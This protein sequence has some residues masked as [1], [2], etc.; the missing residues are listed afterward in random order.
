M[1]GQTITCRFCN[2]PVRLEDTRT[3]E[4]GKA[5]HEECYVKMITAPPTMPRSASE[6]PSAA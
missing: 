5:V 3:D 4:E 6:P 2:K 1:I